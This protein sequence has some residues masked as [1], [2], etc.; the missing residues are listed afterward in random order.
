MWFSSE[1]DIRRWINIAF[2]DMFTLWPFI[3][4]ETFETEVRR[5]FAPGK[6]DRGEVD[7]DRLGLLHAVIALGQRND[8]E[9]LSDE[10]ANSS[11]TELRGYGHCATTSSPRSGL[12]CGIRRKHFEIAR[13]LVPL[14]QCSRSLTAVQT[15]LCMGLYVKSWAAQRMC[16]TYFSMAGYG[17]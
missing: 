1:S 13:D 5:M 4:R 6:A 10:D 8:P 17:A 3:D 2:N 9:L 7:H 14:A 12:T 16:H 15:V 11:K